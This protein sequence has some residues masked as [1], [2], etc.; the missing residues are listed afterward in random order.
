MPRSLRLLAAALWPLLVV[1]QVEPGAPLPNR[2]GD[3]PVAGDVAAVVYWCGAG[4]R[5]AAA[6][7]EAPCGAALARRFV[8]APVDFVAVVAADTVDVPTGFRR[9][10]DATGATASWFA[11]DDPAFVVVADHRGIVRFV[12]EPFA[13]LVD[14]LAGILAGHDDVAAARGARDCRRRFGR[15]LFDLRPPAV[16][17]L[18]AAVAHAPRDGQL[19]GMLY[20][21]AA[22][23]CRD[24]A[25][26]AQLADAALGALADEPRALA[27]FF[28]LAMRGEVRKADFA[29]RA[30]AVAARAEASAAD[31]PAVQLAVL[32]LHVH[33]GDHREIGRR[34]IAARRL[35]RD[36][37]VGCLELA[38]ILA[39]G[40]D[41]AVHADLATLVVDRAAALRGEPRALAAA[42]YGAAVRCA[43]D[44]AAGARVLDGYLAQRDP[45]IRSNNDCWRLLTDQRSMGRWTSFA[46]G[47]A[48]RMTAAESDLAYFEYDTVALAMFLSGRGD[49]AIACAELAVERAGVA[50]VDYADRLR[51]YREAQAPAPR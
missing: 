10:V 44:A 33:A 16:A 18:H 31:D 35:V 41:A 50:G 27:A 45:A 51:W 12:G 1:A 5:A 46:V 47:L 43:G 15:S 24:A 7:A 42:R 26:A 40:P 6:R 38:A 32:R 19:R 3:A 37:A 25:L 21:V 20:L 28:D 23:G 8:D 2:P 30:L 39:E 4:A 9:V 11:A 13:G 29:R 36:D 14:A 48:E 49:D 17:P 22:I 34:A